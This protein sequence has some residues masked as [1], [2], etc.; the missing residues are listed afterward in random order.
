MSNLITTSLCLNITIFLYIFSRFNS[1]KFLGGREYSACSSCYWS[2]IGELGSKAYAAR[3]FTQQ[4][5]PMVVS[6]FCSYRVCNSDAGS[7]GSHVRQHVLYFSNPPWLLALWEAGRQGHINLR[8]LFFSLQLSIVLENRDVLGRGG[9]VRKD[10]WIH[11][12]HLGS[13]DL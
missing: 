1:S 10:I 8:D 9:H 3:R 6:R 13:V 11:A 4:P 12:P 7:R 2:G 5:K